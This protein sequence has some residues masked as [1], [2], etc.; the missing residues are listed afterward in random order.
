M[1]CSRELQK[2]PKHRKSIINVE[3]ANLY[4]LMP[5]FEHGNFFELNSKINYAA[6]GFV[7]SQIV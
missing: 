6:V 1:Q 2:C 3:D 7:Y 4:M 5:F